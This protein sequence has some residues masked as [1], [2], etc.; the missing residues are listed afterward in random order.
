MLLAKE[1]IMSLEESQQ[2]DG[3]VVTEKRGGG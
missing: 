3:L 1:L 2:Q